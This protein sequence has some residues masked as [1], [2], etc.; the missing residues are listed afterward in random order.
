LL[1]NIIF[2]VDTNV[3]TTTRTAYNSFQALADTG[4]FAS[5]IAVVFTFI[6]FRIQKILY[7]LAAS[8]RFFLCLEESPS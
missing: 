6:T 3:E 5:V 1:F 2:L 4:G 8:Q 7:Y